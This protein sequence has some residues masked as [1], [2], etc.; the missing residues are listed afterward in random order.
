MATQPQSFTLIVP[1]EAITDLRER[2]ARAR[3]ILTK[4]PG[5]LGYAHPDKLIGIH[6]NLLA[7]RRDQRAAADMTP[8]EKAYADRLAQWLREETGYQWI[9]GAR[10]QT[11]AFG[12]TDSPASLAAW[13]IEKFRA[14]SDCGGDVET[15]FTRDRLLANISFYWFTGA[16]GSA[17]WPYY[18]RMHRPWPIPEGQTV[19]VP[20]GYA[21]FPRE[22][23]RPP[24]S[25]AAHAYKKHPALERHATRRSFRRSGTAR[26]A[27]QRGARILPAIAGC[28]VTAT[29]GRA[30]TLTRLAALGTLSRTAGEG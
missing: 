1:D 8:E 21:E 16:I 3:G 13:I 29:R 19:N 10:P 12:L 2:L 27:R 7:V 4:P 22:I 17:F 26:R 5:R 11:L 6:L 24:R 23:L 9:Q 25:L 20:T 15:T 14:W 30:P 18:A 28:T